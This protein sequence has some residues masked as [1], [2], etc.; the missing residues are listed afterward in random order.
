MVEE[1]K[2]MSV[3]VLLRDCHVVTPFLLAMTSMERKQQIQCAYRY[4]DTLIALCVTPFLLAM[5]S[6]EQ[7]QQIQ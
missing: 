4:S 2:S 3:S 1:A 7:K 6:M 5:T